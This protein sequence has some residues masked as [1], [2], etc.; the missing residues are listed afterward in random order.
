MNN[1]LIKPIIMDNSTNGMDYNYNVT[2]RRPSTLDFIGV[3]GSF[4]M[5]KNRLFCAILTQG[6]G[7][8]VLFSLLSGTKEDGTVPRY[9]VLG[10][11][12][13][14]A[15]YMSDMVSKLTV[16]FSKEKNISLIYN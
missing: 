4:C 11:I 16:E 3:S 13:T 14:K 1:K 2:V 7:S 5:F 9:V 15:I 10:L 6:D 8:I 12:G